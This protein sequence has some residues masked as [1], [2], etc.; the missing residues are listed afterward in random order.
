MSKLTN[1]T[2]FLGYPIRAWEN[3]FNAAIT[4][5]LACSTVHDMNKV[6]LLAKD[7]ADLAHGELTS[8][9]HVTE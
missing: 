1:V 4:G 3:T 9:E 7:I 5:L 8:P 6:V 2:D